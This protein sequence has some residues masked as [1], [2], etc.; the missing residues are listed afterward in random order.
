MKKEFILKVSTPKLALRQTAKNMRTLAQKSCLTKA[1]AEISFLPFV[2]TVANCKA[3][4]QSKNACQSFNYDQATFSCRLYGESPVGTVAD[5]HSTC[6]A[7]C[8]DNDNG[9]QQAMEAK[10]LHSVGGSCE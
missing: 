2:D 10:G 4:C 3:H 6:G 1:N 8:K 7:M 9:V 5:L